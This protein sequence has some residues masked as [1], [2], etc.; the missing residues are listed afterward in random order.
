MVMHE[1]SKIYVAGH[2]GLIG[3]AIVKKLK[4]LGFSNLLLRTHSELELTDKKNVFDFFSHNKPEYVFLCAGKVGG[5]LDNKT[6][7]ADYLHVNLSIQDNVFEAVQT[8]DVKRIVFLGSSCIYPRDISGP[9][10]E[11]ILFG[12]PIEVTSQGYAAAKIAGVIGCKVYN[13]QYG[14]N[15]FIA[16]VPNSTYGPGD[17]FDLHN[18]HVLSALIRKFHEAK[19]NNNC[20]VTLWGSGNPRREF[21]YSEDVAEAS[22]YAVKNSGLLKNRHYNLGTGK[23]YSIKELAEIICEVVGYK[24]RIC[25]DTDKPD[26]TRQKLLDSS[27]FMSLGWK[28]RM[29]LKE[30]IEQTYKWYLSKI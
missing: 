3:T 21:I 28:P 24:G 25:W 22:I 9:I 1:K 10:K 2:R 15:R 17:N 11:E 26:G 19:K 5:I 4:E 27:E 29:N 14:V 8:N 13:E 7:P 12:G 20:S 18:S 23:D 6:H 16:L 30:G